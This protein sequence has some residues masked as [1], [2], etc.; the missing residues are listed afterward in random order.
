MRHFNVAYVI[1]E[2]REVVIKN[3]DDLT[4]EEAKD[5]FWKLY[6]DTNLADES[7]CVQCSTEIKYISDCDEQ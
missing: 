4:E 1:T 5:L 2:V 3:H 7:E 6:Y